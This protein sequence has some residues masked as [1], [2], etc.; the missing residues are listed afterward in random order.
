MK[1]WVFFF[2]ILVTCPALASGLPHANVS[3]TPRLGGAGSTFLIDAT[4]SRNAAGNPGGIEMRCQM[5]PSSGWSEFSSQLKIE[6]TPQT[7]GSYTAKCQVR[8]RQTQL[9][10]TTYRT[11]KVVSSFPRSA[12]IRVEK[13][14]TYVGQP[15]DFEII[16]STG[17]SDNQNEVQ[18]R[19]DFDHDGIWDTGWSRAK[20]V[21]HV[22][23]TAMTVSPRAEVKFSDDE[24]LEVDGIVPA[25]RT[26]IGSI[27][28]RSRWS[29]L[30]I[31]SAPVVPP[32]VDVSP[33]TSGFS[34]STFFTF[35]ASRSRVPSLGWLEWSFDGQQWQRFPRADQVRMQFDSPGTHNVRV[36]A[37]FGHANPLCEQTEISVD[38]DPD[39]VDFR[40]EILV[41]NL[42]NSSPRWNAGADTRQS[43]FF[44]EVGDELRFSATLRSLPVRS[45]A[46]QYRWKISQLWN[47]SADPDPDF[48][49]W[50]TPFSSQ[51]YTHH[52]FDRTGDFLVTLEVRNE[53]DTVVS[54][55]QKV[56]V[57]QNTVPTGTIRHT[58]EQ[59]Y[60]GERV[61]FFA[62]NLNE[63][64]GRAQNTSQPLDVRFDLDGDGLWDS[65][66]RTGNSAEW[67]Y[68][69]AGTVLVQMQIRDDGKNV[70]TIRDTIEVLAFP[71]PQARLKI[72]KK[73]PRVDEAVTF[74]ASGSVG[75]N[76]Q[77][78]WSDPEN[79][80]KKITPKWDNLY[81]QNTSTQ[82]GFFGSARGSKIVRTFS[83]PGEHEMSLWVR[84]NQGQVNQVFFSVFVY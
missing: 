79:V 19:W 25:T 24:I 73:Y 76:L 12:S 22:F 42:T 1:K 80:Q 49:R 9:I 23:D 51:N 74:D 32:I 7:I 84:D 75:R 53:D 41:Q 83:T 14:K 44:S 11:Y 54:V 52:I 31:I 35:D 47:E 45:Q 43:I 15:V 6:F 5:T 46:Y 59:I 66:F 81:W 13:T 77:F 38:V 64:A 8:D 68:Q 10:S 82:N 40:A 4:D 2:G 48:S 60:V 58:P 72:S 71:A 27:L 29:K 67:V 28:P 61:R 56:R 20:K 37:C 3:I 78:F 57:Q 16:L 63:N 30:H 50:Q 33:G 39:P 62:D 69:N 26:L 18:V 65:D 17:A 55:A 36:R 21:S 34:E 70:R